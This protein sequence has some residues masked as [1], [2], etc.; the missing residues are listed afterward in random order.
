MSY[1]IVN[2][3]VVKIQK[4]NFMIARKKAFRQIRRIELH[5]KH[6]VFQLP[7]VD[8]KQTQIDI[9]WND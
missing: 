9:I 4:S 1:K 6:V 2:N 5:T 8:A 7:V 3:K